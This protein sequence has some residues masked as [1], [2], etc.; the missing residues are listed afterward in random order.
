M[1]L[2]VVLAIVGVV[3]A[4]AAPNV[5]AVL[6]RLSPETPGDRLAA[7]LQVARSDAVRR[8]GTACIELDA[9]TGVYR[10]T[11]LSVSRDSVL[12][13]GQVE[14]WVGGEVTGSRVCFYP[15]GVATSG[16]RVWLGEDRGTALKV[17]PWDGK[18]AIVR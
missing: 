6:R 17:S 3:T 7:V 15:S 10:V 11:L 2:L 1:E 16:W 5:G 8:G 13:T 12:S 9:A 18:I 4:V 14:A